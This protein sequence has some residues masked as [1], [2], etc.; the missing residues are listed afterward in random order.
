MMQRNFFFF[1]V[2]VVEV[3][4]RLGSFRS[5]ET[6]DVSEVWEHQKFYPSFV[7]QDC[8]MLWAED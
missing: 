1:A 3:S 2:G 4:E 5:F 8:W 6:F 7:V